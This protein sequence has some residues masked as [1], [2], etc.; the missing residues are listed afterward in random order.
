[1]NNQIFFFLNNLTHQSAF[2][3]NLVTFFAVDFI[4]IVIVLA[5]LLLF[6]YKQKWQDFA[7]L[8]LSGGAA[9][10][11]SQVLKVL[12]HTPRPFESFHEVQPLFLE[13]GYAFP[14]GHTMVAAAIAFTLFF[15]HKKAGY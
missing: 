15:I 10:V 6:F 4:Y 14:S 11:L 7:L 3:D 1:M 13:T 9:Y 12:I 5:F 8:C 2:F